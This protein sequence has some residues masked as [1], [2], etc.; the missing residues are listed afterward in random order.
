MKA[1][2]VEEQRYLKLL[3]KSETA[4]VLGKS[5][6][7]VAKGIKD[8]SIPSVCIA[9]RKLVPLAALENLQYAV[10]LPADIIERARIPIERMLQI[11]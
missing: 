5:R 4:R 8:G 9:G 7:F 1:T 2:R 3:T 10:E 6:P 11:Q